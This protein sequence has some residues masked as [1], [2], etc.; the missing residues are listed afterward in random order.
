MGPLNTQLG[1]TPKLTKLTDLSGSGALAKKLPI[2]LLLLSL[3]H[4]PFSSDGVPGS[5]MVCTGVLC[6][7]LLKHMEWQFIAQ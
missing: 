1:F 4:P 7:W 5:E 3:T 6:V 2:H